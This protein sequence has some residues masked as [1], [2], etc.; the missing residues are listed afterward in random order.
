MYNF[1]E[2]TSLFT[3]KKAL[4]QAQNQTELEAFIEQLMQNETYRKELGCCAKNLIEDHQGATE[5]NIQ[6]IGQFMET[7]AIQ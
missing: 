4:L 6:K 1:K 2:M 5:K 3:S 7:G